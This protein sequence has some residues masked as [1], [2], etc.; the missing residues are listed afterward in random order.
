MRHYFSDIDHEEID[1]TTW[2]LERLRASA[3]VGAVAGYVLLAG[4]LFAKVDWLRNLL[5][6][7]T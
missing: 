1:L 3:L 6:P 7:S 2:L 5:T 4:V